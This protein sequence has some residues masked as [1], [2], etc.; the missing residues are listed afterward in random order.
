MDNRTKAVVAVC[1]IA[2]FVAGAYVVWDQ[3]AHHDDRIVIECS[4]EKHN[5]FGCAVLDVDMRS[6]DSLNVPFG[7]DLFLEFNDSKYRAIYV[8][9]YNGVPSFSVF[10]SF[11]GPQKEYVVGVFNGTFPEGKGLSVGDTVKLSVAGEN[12][13]YSR[14][15]NY[16]AGYSNNRDDYVSDQAFA[17]CRM[18]TGGDI[19]DGKVYR[20]ST[21]WGLH[22][23]G[24]ISDAFLKGAGVSYLVGMDKSEQELAEVV[25][26]KGYLYS[27]QLF[28]DG[29]VCSRFLS[30]AVQ[31]HPEEIRW[32]IDRM[33]D[34]DGSLGI[35]CKL[36]KD[37]TGV[38]CLFLQAIAGA[39]LEEA[40]D[41]FMLSYINYYGIEKGTDEY[42]AVYEICL[43][44]LLYLFQHPELIDHMLEVD[45]SK[46][47]LKDYDLKEVITSFLTDYVG[48]PAEKIDALRAK[49]T[50]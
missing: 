17:N 18:L 40:T 47:E 4:V 39:T 35:F 43:L 31:S 49:I 2:V 42:E 19:A 28:Q 6:M 29:S 25:A 45:W 23:R 48:I 26:A 24:D 12:E 1:V 38:Y 8:E 27:S 33:L 37:R 7:T 10:V 15:P 36:G 14:I 22:G 46:V 34:A 30:P 32:A 9:N 44:P 11:I 5:E 3:T 41:E 20:C 21:P 50:A 16:L 13:Y